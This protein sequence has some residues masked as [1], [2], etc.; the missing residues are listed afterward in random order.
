MRRKIGYY[1]GIIGM[2]IALVFANCAS[3]YN[4]IC[5]NTLS[6]F[7]N[8]DGNDCY[9]NLPVQYIGDYQIETFDFLR[10]NILI[11]DYNILLER[12]NLKISI[13][14]N[15]ASDIYGNIEGTFDLVYLEEYGNITISKMNEP[16][17]KSEADSTMNMYNINI[18]RKLNE[19]EIK[20]LIKE[21]RKGNTGSH[22]S[23]TYEAV[24][25]N[26]FGIFG[27]YDDFE[28]RNAF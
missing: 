17:I 23:I 5:Y 20:K 9:L 26:D 22:F 1:I 27:I 2:L 6:I 18:E 10:G 28:L 3:N 12:D 8:R 24:I 11:G 19:N 7:F 13:L 15:T 25:D 4:F 14:L 21:Y 16:I